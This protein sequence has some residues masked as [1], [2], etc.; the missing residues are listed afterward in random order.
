MLSSVMSLVAC[1][2]RECPS[3]TGHDRSTFLK[4]LF[5]DLSARLCSVLQSQTV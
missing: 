1:D 3:E 5:D 2:N 4:Y